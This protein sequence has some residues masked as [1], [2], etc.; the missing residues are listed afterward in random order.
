MT[1]EDEVSPTGRP[2]WTEGE[3]VRLASHFSGDLK[4]NTEGLSQ[5]DL[6]SLHVLSLAVRQVIHLAGP[7]LVLFGK[8]ECYSIFTTEIFS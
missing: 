7:V 2:R 8:E 3:A 1:L 6:C 4:V 5:G